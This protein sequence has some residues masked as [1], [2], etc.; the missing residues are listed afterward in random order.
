MY[1]IFNFNQAKYFF[2]VYSL[3]LYVVLSRY[4]GKSTPVSGH[5]KNLIGLKMYKEVFYDAVNDWIEYNLFNFS[6]VTVMKGLNND[7]VVSLARVG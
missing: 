7:E 2:T 1:F 6:Q 4:Y 3:S 5:C